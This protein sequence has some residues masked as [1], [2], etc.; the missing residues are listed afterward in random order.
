MWTGVCG[1]KG[2]EMNEYKQGFID[3]LKAF[4]WWK[5]GKEVLGTS[6]IPLKDTIDNVEDVWNY[7]PAFKDEYK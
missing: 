2:E 7:D 1:E 5:D 4:A 6:E 3:G